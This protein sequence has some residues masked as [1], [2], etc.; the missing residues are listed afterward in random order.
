M[1]YYHKTNGGVTLSGGEALLQIDAYELAKFC[2][3]RE[4]KLM[5]ERQ[6]MQCRLYIKKIEEWEN[7]LKLP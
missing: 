1:K 4:N 7:W 5:L 2:K 6:V 3:R